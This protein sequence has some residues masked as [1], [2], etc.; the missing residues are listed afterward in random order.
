MKNI[1]LVRTADYSELSVK[2][3]RIFSS[4]VLSNPTGSF[5]FATGSTPLG[6]YKELCRLHSEGVVSLSEL[7]AFN[8][9]EYYPIEPTN[10]QSYSFFMAQNLFDPVGLL[11]EQRNIPGGDSSSPKAECEQY[12]EKLTSKSPIEMQILGI[13]TNGH[14]GFNEPSDIFHAKTHLVKLA[15]STIKSN[16]RFFDSPESVPKMAITMG[17]GTIMMAKRVLLIV[18]GEGKAEM[19][20]D[21]LTGPIT[22]LVPA[23][24]L[25]LHRDVIVVADE[26]AAKYL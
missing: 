25:Q 13:G 23:S 15:E 22:P 2:A 1:T 5:G 16:A 24:A 10:D 7:T 11:V 8:L 18:S 21:A 6:M 19:L 3:A 17:V 14:I 12:E 4:S 20:R 26:A 9:D